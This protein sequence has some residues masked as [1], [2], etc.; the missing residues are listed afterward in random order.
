MFDIP[1]FNRY[2]PVLIAI[3]NIL[4]LAQTDESSIQSKLELLREFNHARLLP[5]YTRRIFEKADNT[6]NVNVNTLSRLTYW[7]I[8]EKLQ[9][10]PCFIPDKK[11]LASAIPIYLSGDQL[12]FMTDVK[13]SRLSYNNQSTPLNTVLSRQFS[14]LI[15]A[16]NPYNESESKQLFL[17]NTDHRAHLYRV[18]LLRTISVRL[19]TLTHQ[20][21]IRIF[22]N[23][24]DYDYNTYLEIDF[25]L[26]NQVE[27]NE[28]E[29]VVKC[30]EV[31]EKEEQ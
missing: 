8:R 21:I 27:M 30:E 29:K 31:L 20:E 24:V 18:E 2:D 5:Q 25:N 28:I 4:A 16:L 10:Q 12:R 22:Q 1:P 13:R 7:Y 26:L 23:S 17:L 19:L 3:E 14:S 11:T 9:N 6:N 15:Q